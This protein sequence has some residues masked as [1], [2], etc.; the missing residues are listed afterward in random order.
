MAP[1][2]PFRDFFPPDYFSRLNKQQSRID[3]ELKHFSRI[4]AAAFSPLFYAAPV[5]QIIEKRTG[6][7]NFA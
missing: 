5:F 4:A 2:V 3:L 1:S 7:R 6:G